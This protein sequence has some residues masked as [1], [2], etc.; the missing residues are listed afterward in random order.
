MNVGKRHRRAP[1][2]ARLSL[3]MSVIALALACFPALAQAECTSSSCVQYTESIPKPEGENTPQGHQKTPA[4]VS[5]TGKDGNSEPSQPNGSK[6]AKEAEG[7]EEGE[8]SEKKSGAVPGHSG[9]N[10]QGK[11]GGSTHEGGKNA[12]NPGAQSKSGVQAS[13]SSDSGGSSPL[14]PI[15][16]AIAVLAAISVAVVTIRQRRQRGGPTAT[17]SPKAN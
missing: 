8:A 3:L 7:S 5:K 2:W 9:D 12:V 1:Q 16:I 15:L 11:P 4:K 17:A 6:G 13:K 14:V 10:G